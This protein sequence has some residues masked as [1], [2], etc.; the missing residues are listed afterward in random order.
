MVEL[1]LPELQ[2]TIDQMYI[3]P[4]SGKVPVTEDRESA[5]VR[6]SVPHHGV[7]EDQDAGDQLARHLHPH[8]NPENS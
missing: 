3:G 5:G 6:S 2:L 4:G 8:A 7:G 1:W